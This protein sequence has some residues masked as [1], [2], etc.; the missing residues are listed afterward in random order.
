MRSVSA[1]EGVITLANW[2]DSSVN[3]FVATEHQRASEYSCV[4]ILLH[5]RGPIG[6]A[7]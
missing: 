7:V 3:T 1:T 4:E 6:E 2:E 5:P